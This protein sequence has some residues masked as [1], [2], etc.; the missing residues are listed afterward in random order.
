MYFNVECDKR[1]NMIL[2]LK[3]NLNKMIVYQNLTINQLIIFYYYIN[4]II[5]LT[6][7]SNL[8]LGMP[9]HLCYKC[10]LLRNMLML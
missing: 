7:V 6:C 9:R 2:C 1:V 10:S 8:E 5:I 3:Y 4:Y